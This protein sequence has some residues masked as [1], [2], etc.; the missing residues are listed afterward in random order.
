MITGK[1]LL[2]IVTLSSHVVYLQV[3]VYK[4]MAVCSISTVQEH[5]GVCYNVLYRK[6]SWPQGY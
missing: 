5:D 4:Y 1:T 2:V 3:H 6:A